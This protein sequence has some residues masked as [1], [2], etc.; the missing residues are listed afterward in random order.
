MKRKIIS[1]CILFVVIFLSCKKDELFVDGN[2]EVMYLSDVLLDDQTYYRYV[3]NDSNLVSEESSKVDFMMHHYNDKNQLISSDYYWNNAILNSDVKLIETT[4][5]QSALITSANGIK[6]GTIKYEY[7]DDQLNKATYSRPSGV[8]EYSTFNYDANNRIE[9]QDL[10]YN[11]IATGYIEYRYDGRGNLIKELLYE[12]S[13][14]GATE[15]STTTKYVFDNKQNPFYSLKSLILPGI[16]TNR[17]NIVKEINTVHSNA[18]QGTDKSQIT[19]NSYEY[20]I[21]GYPVSKN[22]NIKYL[23]E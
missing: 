4:L 3:Y 10:F 21:N 12:L 1:L 15:L 6:G 23:Y 5:S 17:N 2:Y 9:R 11:N 19:E 7:N 18:G 14:T 16:N 22:G 13:A 8:S 20:N